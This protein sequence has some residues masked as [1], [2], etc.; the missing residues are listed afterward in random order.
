MA[1]T[2]KQMKFCEEYAI[3][4]NGTQSYLIAFETENR[5]TA[6]DNASKLLAKPEI[7]EY[8]KEVR[9]EYIS[10]VGDKAEFLAAQL[11]DEI[12]YRD[13]D[14]KKSP[15]WIA[16]INLLQK[17]CGLQQTKVDAIVNTPDIH[18]TIGE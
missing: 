5:K 3:C 8:V 9:K 17:Q 14:G 12:S 4:G 10:R 2:A 16:A 1:L 7:Q 11:I 13:E 6:R 15:N 18:I